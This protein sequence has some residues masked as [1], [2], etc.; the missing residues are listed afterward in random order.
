MPSQRHPFHIVLLGLCLVHLAWFAWQ[1]V[2]PT[3]GIAGLLYPNGTPVGGDFINLWSVARLVLEGRVEDIY[4][5]ETFMAYQV[6]L[7][8]AP[9]GI[10]FWAYPP[11]SLLLAWPL[12]LFP[13]YAALALW[14]VLGLGV[15][16]LGCRRLGLGPVEAVIV[17]LSPASVL[18]LYYGQT[19]N[20]AAGLLLL[21]LAPRRGREIGAI[22]AAALLTMKPQMGLL[23]PLFWLVERRWRAILLTG[24]VS[25]GL[26]GLAWLVFGPIVWSDYV[27]VTLPGLSQLE[28]EGTG[29]FMLMIPSIFMALRILSGDGDLALILHLALAVPIVLLAG[30]RLRSVPDPMRRAGVVLAGTALLTPYLHNYDLTMVAVAALVVLR[31][32]APGRRGEL[33][34]CAFVVLVLALPQMVVGLNFVGMPV[35]PLIT[36]TLLLLI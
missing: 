25:L 28:R 17:L 19:G 13:F 11:H 23:L 26:V 21:A 14:S 15:L 18:C 29:P 31:R 30:W 10:R 32:F 35:S 3:L 1:Q 24:A 5:Y 22:G 4:R 33:V 34:A 20:L 12:G 16:A 9:I 7:T 8:G 2:E 36:L 6:G 27:G